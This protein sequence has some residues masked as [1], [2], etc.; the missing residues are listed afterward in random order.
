MQ[1]TRHPFQDKVGTTPEQ[2]LNFYQAQVRPC[3]QYY[4]PFS[5][6]TRQLPSDRKKTT[7]NENRLF[8]ETHHITTQRGQVILVIYL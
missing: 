6:E 7:S 5:P 2:L 1:K 3:T 8:D 4:L